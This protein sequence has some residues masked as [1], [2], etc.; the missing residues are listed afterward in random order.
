MLKN[1]LTIIL[2]TGLCIVLIVLFAL[3]QR[4]KRLKKESELNE[5]KAKYKG[6]EGIKVIVSPES[7][8]LLNRLPR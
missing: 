2:V 6:E 7:T 1:G 3:V 8:S 5:L 4:Q